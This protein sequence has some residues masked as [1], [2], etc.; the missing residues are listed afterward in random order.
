M[1]NPETYIDRDSA[2]KAS[3]TTSDGQICWRVL[4]CAVN[5][6]SSMYKLDANAKTYKCWSCE[7]FHDI[8]LN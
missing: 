3:Q 5:E 1:N 6:N 8:P 7:E 4:Y 2:L